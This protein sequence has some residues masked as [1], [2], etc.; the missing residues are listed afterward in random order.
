MTNDTQEGVTN[1]VRI[2]L[3]THVPAVLWLVLTGSVMLCWTWRMW[4]DVMIDFGR[5][6]YVPWRLTEGS[7]LYRDISYLDAGPVS[8][9]WNALV[10]R[11]FG[12]GLMTLVVVNLVLMILLLVMIH[13]LARILTSEFAAVVAS[14]VF[15]LLF[16]F[17]QH[18]FVGNFN[19][20][21]P[22][23][24]PLVHGLLFSIGCLSCVTVVIR[25]GHRAWLGTGGILAGLA[26]LTKPD[27]F[28]ALG[29][30]VGG[31]FCLRG[32]TDREAPRRTAKDFVLFL[33]WAVVPPVL[34]FLWLWKEMPAGMAFQGI[35]GS[36]KCLGN[37]QIYAI[38]FYRTGMGTDNLGHSL[39]QITLWSAG[40]ATGLG[41][42]ALLAARLKTEGWLRRVAPGAAFLVA[43]VLMF[44]AV[45]KSPFDVLRPMP[46]AL[47]LSGLCLLKAL[48]TAG[49]DRDTRWRL[50]A[51][52]MAITFALTLLLKIL[53]YA[54]LVHYG[55]VLAMPGT[56][57]CVI[58]LT[59]GIPRWLARRGAC[60]AVFTAGALGLIA[61]L[62]VDRLQAMDA[63]Y[64][65]KTLQV[66]RGRDAFWADYRGFYVQQALAR[67]AREVKPGQTLVVMPEG[68]MIN[69]LSRRQNPT[70]FFS[71]NPFDLLIF[72]E[73]RML[74]S[75]QAHPP[76]FVI[77]EHADMSD[78]GHQY[79]GRDY[80]RAMFRWIG[81]NY[82]SQEVLGAKPFQGDRYGLE[83][84]RRNAGPTQPAE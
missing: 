7:R 77:F 17:G 81:T 47:L 40:Y 69:Y 52:L 58:A 66:A 74:A 25:G 45:K 8:P 31:G 42:L 11:T 67:I 18:L 64:Q 12:V 34:A 19:Y 84:L 78:L 43:A 13:S 48:F 29:A 68:V 15:L 27:P 16:A 3:I 61:A 82:T 73:N 28:L 80:A 33:G 14:T 2:A 24:H 5:E 9:W 65:R 21:T 22:Y 36:W 79:F 10:F 26:F 59:H 49:G 44:A 71:F 20:L 60:G 57:I 35:V 41:L 37:T 46:V 1:R 30:A 72:G 70:P 76:D 54:R 51:A 23:A 56:L 53:L 83:I 38:E 39:K 6:L 50:I 32:L 63:I 4:P 62:I 75:L 55:F